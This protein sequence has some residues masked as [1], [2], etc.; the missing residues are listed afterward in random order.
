[1]SA[2]PLTPDER[3]RAVARV[4]AAGILRLRARA[5]LPEPAAPPGPKILTESGPNCL[6]VLP[7]TRLS[8]PPG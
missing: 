5:A 7:E 3:R 6:E 4:L 1:M 2:D 8:V